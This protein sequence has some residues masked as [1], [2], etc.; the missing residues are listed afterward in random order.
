MGDF[1]AWIKGM[2]GM[3]FGLT[4][5]RRGAEIPACAGMTVNWTTRL[6]QI[7]VQRPG[8]QI[9]PAYQLAGESVRQILLHLRQ[10]PI[11]LGGQFGVGGVG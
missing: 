9:G 11:P 8:L 6:M 4:Q 10:E 1:L 2:E 7:S 5:R 3:G